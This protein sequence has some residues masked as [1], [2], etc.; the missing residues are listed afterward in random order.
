MKYPLSSRIF[1]LSLFLLPQGTSAATLLIE[2]NHPY[3]QSSVGYGYGLSSWHGMT[4]ALNNS[5]G[6]ANI[7]VNTSPL[8]DLGYL[9][10]FDRLWVTPPFPGENL[11]AQEV[12]NIGA[13]IAT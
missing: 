10:S 1:I 7:T 2:Q 3:V 8:T 9:L 4:A 6:A 11:S 5:F 12:A 13:F